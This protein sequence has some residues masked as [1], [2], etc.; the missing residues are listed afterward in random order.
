MWGYSP[1]NVDLSQILVY[2]M[3]IH[4]KLKTM[5]LC[6]HWTQEDMAEKL[7]W[8]L[9]TYAKIE[10]GDSDIKLDKLKHIAEVIGADVADLLDT[11]DKAI[12][13]FAENCGQGCGQG[14]LLAHTILLSE[15]QCAHELE[16]AHLIIDNKDKEITWLNKEVE[17]LQEIIA[18]LKQRDSSVER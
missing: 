8:A 6:K 11:N 2:F 12:F 5:R 3:Q 1:K 4:E 15:A 7:G 17:R 16:K 13:N 9:N 18:L 10:R 14:N